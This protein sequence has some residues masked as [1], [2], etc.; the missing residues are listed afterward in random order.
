[1]AQ[2]FLAVRRSKCN[3]FNAAK[4]YSGVETFANRL[5]PQPVQP[6]EAL[7]FGLSHRLSTRRQIPARPYRF[8]TA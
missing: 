4:N 5:F 3:K 7:F 6:P 8:S 1:V 2:P